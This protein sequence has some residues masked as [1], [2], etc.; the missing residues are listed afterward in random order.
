MTTRHWLDKFL[1]RRPTR[2]RTPSRTWTRLHC[3]QFEPR[4]LLTATHYL[5]VP[6]LQVVLA[7]TTQ[8]TN[9]AGLSA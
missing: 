2:P 6:S 7:T 8:P 3:E 5:L 1:P 9:D 4:T